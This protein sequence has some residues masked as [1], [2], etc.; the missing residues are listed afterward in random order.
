MLTCSRQ[1]LQRHI[2]LRA[3]TR[4]EFTRAMA[5]DVGPAEGEDFDQHL[6]PPPPRATTPPVPA[7]AAAAGQQA[8]KQPEVVA[9]ADAPTPAPRNQLQKQLSAR[10]VVDAQEAMI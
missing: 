1:V 10:T 2:G 9:V 5:G 3:P 7:A 8:P 4:K 6:G